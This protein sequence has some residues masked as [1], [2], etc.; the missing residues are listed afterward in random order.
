[1][2]TVLFQLDKDRYAVDARC[3]VEIVPLVEFKSVPHVPD[4]V[5]GMFNYH[6]TVVPVLDLCRLMHQR[7]TRLLLSSR[8]ILVNYGM[9]CSL[10]SGAGPRILGLLAE[11][12]T[13]AREIEQSAVPSPVKAPA[14]PYLGG[15]FLHDGDMSQCLKPAELLSAEL[16]K[17]LF[18]ACAEQAWAGS[19]S[20]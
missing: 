16:Q 11:Q 15:I 8:I 5:A 4:F 20:G 6:G 2:L 14:A 9:L 7:A 3:I 10:P 19:G 18:V 12:V 1:M 17:M 13:E